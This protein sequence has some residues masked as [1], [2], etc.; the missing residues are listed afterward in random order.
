VEWGDHDVSAT[1]SVIMPT[2]NRSGDVPRAAASVLSQDIDGLELVVVDDG[3]SDDTVKV[4]EGLMSQDPRIRVVRN[5]VAVGPCE[6][7]NRG[8]AV[9]QGDLVAFCDDDDAWLPGVGRVLVDYLDAHPDVGAVSSWHLVL[10]AQTGKA[11]VFRGPLVHETHELLWQNFV[12]ISAMIRRS[13]FSF[14][15]RFDPDFATGEDWDLWLRCSRERPIKTVPH[16]GYLYTQHGGPRATRTA[17]TQIEGRRALLAK[18]GESMTTSCRL[19][20]ETVLAGYEE[21]RTG[22]LRRLT[23]GLGG[24]PRDT[25]FVAFLLASSLAASRV[26]QRR[27]DPG[28]QSRLM[29]RLV[30]A[31]RGSDRSRPERGAS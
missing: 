25:A 12:L 17:G 27:Q 18:H 20:H 22:M 23:A 30:R 16:V 24:S 2:R 26:G 19:F 5:D 31:D 11:A 8:L 29:A 10:H 1:L 7:R 9:A 6:A 21:G 14:E 3:S 4:L 28:L 15:I 13:A